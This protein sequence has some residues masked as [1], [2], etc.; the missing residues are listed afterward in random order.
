MRDTLYRQ[1]LDSPAQFVFDERVA[2]V[3]DNMISRSVPL[4]EDIQ[5]ATAKLCG[6][7]AR[8]HTTIFDLGCSSGTTLALI[9]AEVSDPT[10]RI[11][12]IDN[13]PAM[14]AECRNKLS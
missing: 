8:P 7:L 4:Y 14:L 9:A 5:R 6:R 11:V 1:P 10:V 12:G 3:F 2:A 13:S